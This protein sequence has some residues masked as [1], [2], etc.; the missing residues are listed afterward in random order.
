MR[1]DLADLKLFVNVVEA[2]SITGG[3]ERLNLA[4]AAAST[5]IR[6]MEAVLGTPLLHR[7]RQGVAPTQAGHTLVLHARILLRQAERM[8]GDLGQYAQ[9]LRG[10]VRLLSNT[11]ALTEFLAEPLSA[12]LAA[13]PRVNIDLEE[14]L[15][16]EIVAAVADGAADIGIV[17]G[18]VAMAGLETLPFRTDRFVTVVAPRHPLAAAASVAFA[19]M[20]DCDFVGLDRTSALQRFL[21]EKAERLGR[22]LKLRVQLRSFDA[23]CRFVECDVGVGIVPATTALRLSRTMAIRRV[24]LADAWAVR[25]LKIC[26]RR[27][28]DLPIYARQLVQH[29]AVQNKSGI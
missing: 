9:G 2:G 21:S 12:F 5:R 18:T 13:H 27:A 6:N 26:L 20:L 29:L 25:E 17:A 1:F 3:A 7:Q 22:R 15:S 24:E 8:H 10:Q 16:D 23:V 28:A 11:N 19:E 4:L 14:R